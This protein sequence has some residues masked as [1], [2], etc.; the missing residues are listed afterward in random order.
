MVF[1]HFPWTI[2][3]ELKDKANQWFSLIS[4]YVMDIEEDLPNSLELPDIAR[5][6]NMESVLYF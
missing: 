4:A 3:F 5:K 1:A 6:Q 2:C